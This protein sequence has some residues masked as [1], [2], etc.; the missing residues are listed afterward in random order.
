M[1][2]WN[3]SGVALEALTSHD[4]L[5]LGDKGLRVYQMLVQHIDRGNSGLSLASRKDA[6]YFLRWI[7]SV[8][9]NTTVQVCHQ[10]AMGSKTL[11]RRVSTVILNV[12]RVLESK[13]KRAKAVSREPW[14]A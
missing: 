4:T 13:K 14:E 1:F 7:M 12:Y 10:K 8:I 11:E 5:E 3:F 6:T 9:T 2:T